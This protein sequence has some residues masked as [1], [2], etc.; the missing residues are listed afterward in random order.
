M[1]NFAR[2]SYLG[3]REEFR[4]QFENPIMEGMV[5]FEELK[6]EV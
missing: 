1:V 4:N 5:R 3:T 6:E 2:P